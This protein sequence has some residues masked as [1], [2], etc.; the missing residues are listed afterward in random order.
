[1]H[2]FIV[3]ELDDLRQNIFKYNKV[4]NEVDNRE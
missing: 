4:I 3:S 2:V 1:M